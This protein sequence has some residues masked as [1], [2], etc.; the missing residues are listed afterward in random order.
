VLLLIV[1]V[2]LFLKLFSWAHVHHDL[3]LAE[4]ESSELDAADFEGCRRRTPAALPPRPS[5]A[6][7][8]T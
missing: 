5:H 6:Y 3:R 1:S 2:T 8:A 4:K 7:H